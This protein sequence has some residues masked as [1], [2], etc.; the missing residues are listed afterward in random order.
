MIDIKM[1]CTAAN[2]YANGEAISCME[3]P[4]LYV[5]QYGTA[6]TLDSQVSVDKETGSIRVFQPMH[7]S[8]DEYKKGRPR[9]DF[10]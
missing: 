3:Y 4:T 9:I 6:K 7:I 1:A 5:F 8:L 10:K 2:E